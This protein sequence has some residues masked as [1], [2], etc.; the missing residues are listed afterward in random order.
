MWHFSNGEFEVHG[1]RDYLKK[2]LNIFVVGFEDDNGDY[3][4]EIADVWQEYQWKRI[5]EEY[6]IWGNDD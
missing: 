6:G 5:C 2:E 4:E 1:D 3:Y